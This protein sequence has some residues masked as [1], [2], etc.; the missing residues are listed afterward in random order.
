MTPPKGLIFIGSGDF[1]KQGEIF[2]KLFTELGGLKPQD[3]VLD[4]GSG[5]GRM[6]VPLTGYL[7]EKGS[8]EGFDI[9]RIG[10]NWCR[11]YITSRY[12]NFRFTHVPLVN[13]LYSNTGESADQFHYPYPE[14]SFDFVFLTSV[15]T[16]MLP[17]DVAQYIKEIARVLAPGGKCF[18]TFFILD[19][20]SLEFMSRQ[21]AP[22]FPFEYEN[23]YLHNQKV[24][25]A[26]VGF[27]RSFVDQMLLNSKLSL[28]LFK[29][30]FWC[31]RPK[32]ES[33]DFQDILV[34]GKT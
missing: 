33:T 30:G 4:I 25:E 29:P 13:S 2:L 14:N 24:P 5:I 11:K 32:A 19:K 22:F 17:A 27:K 12:P 15:F 34:F 7:S 9:M 21:E 28:Y 18:A 16:H 6:A 31:G 1:K 8:Y 10:V 3:R 26:N 20:S 23:Y